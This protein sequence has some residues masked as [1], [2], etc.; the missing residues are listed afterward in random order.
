MKKKLLK[1]SITECVGE[2][3][4]RTFSKKLKLTVWRSRG[5]LKYI[6]TKVQTT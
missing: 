6:E 2:T 5:L 1:K 3:T 4:P